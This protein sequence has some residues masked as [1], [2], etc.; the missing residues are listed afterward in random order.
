MARVIAESKM[1]PL[2][3]VQIG[4]RMRKVSEAG[5]EVVMES[6]AALGCITD[7]IQVRMI[8]RGED[9]R[10]E[11]MAGGH[12]ME[13]ARRLGFPKIRAQIWEC[14]ADE[15][16]LF[17][18]DDNLARAELSVLELCTFMARRHEVYV[19][20]HPETAH[21]GDRGNQYVGGKQTDKMSFCQLIAEK[22]GMSERHARRLVAIG[23][24]L[25][26]NSVRWLESP[27]ELARVDF[28]NLQDIAKIEGEEQEQ[29]ASLIATGGA[30]R[31]ITALHQVRG[32]SPAPVR[33]EDAAYDELFV[34]FKKLNERSKAE[35]LTYLWM[36]YPQMM[37]AAKAEAAK[38]EKAAEE[39]A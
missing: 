15:A 29:V 37:D 32:T 20:L 35:F 7:A 31:V 3:D 17:E 13:A 8:G 14:N 39:A 33:A 16:E 19:R 38:R 26:R 27:H 21:G 1:L 23:K 12:R 30:K 36:S 18:I 11:L 2:G 25:T 6:A 34:R 24:R 22:R 28:K 4:A 9:Q 5:V 10:Y